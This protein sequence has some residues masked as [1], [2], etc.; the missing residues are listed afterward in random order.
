ALPLLNG[1]LVD[2]ER[3]AAVFELVLHASRQGGQFTRL[4]YGHETGIQTVGERGTKDKAT[5]FHAEY[6]INIHLQ[7]V[8]GERV[9][10]SGEP[11]LVL[12][13]RCDVIEE[14]ALLGKIRYLPNQC[15]QR[16]TV[17]SGSRCHSPCSFDAKCT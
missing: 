7:I 10:K 6:Q 15:L 16:F 9:D 2:F 13:E 5:R 17:H 4:A 11:E 8:F 14:N 12:P 3:I 1:V